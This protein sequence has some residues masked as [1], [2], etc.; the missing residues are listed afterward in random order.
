VAAAWFELACC[1]CTICS[2]GSSIDG[3][4]AVQPVIPWKRFNASTLL[5]L[6]NE[7]SGDVASPFQT[8]SSTNSS[9]GN[10]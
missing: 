5:K 7:A 3:A 4:A 6:L 10:S 1:E 9:N 2:A 8:S